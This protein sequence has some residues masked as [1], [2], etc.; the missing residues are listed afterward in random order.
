MS[1]E[2]PKNSPKQFPGTANLYGRLTFPDLNEYSPTMS[3]KLEL[4]EGR[5]IEASYELSNIAEVSNKINEFLN[6]RISREYDERRLA[7]WFVEIFQDA[8]IKPPSMN[9][10]LEDLRAMPSEHELKKEVEEVEARQKA[11]EETKSVE[12]QEA[13]SSESLEVPK[14][15]ELSQELV[16]GK[17]KP[18]EDTID[19]EKESE[20]FEEQV[21]EGEEE[22]S[23]EPKEHLSEDESSESTEEIEENTQEASDS[24][25]KSH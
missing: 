23:K 8:G 9:D 21:E 1:L 10:L 6:S 18:V 5:R 25:D 22:L 2:N 20:D 14:T 11:I 7:R 4:L 19:S 13:Q 12:A 3:C 17:A 24:E 15:P 16:E